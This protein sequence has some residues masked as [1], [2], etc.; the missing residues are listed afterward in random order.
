MQALQRE[1]TDRDELD[2][3][4]LF[5]DFTV[6]RASRAAAGACFRGRLAH[7]ARRRAALTL[8]AREAR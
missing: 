3:D 4:V 7:V 8:A 5:I 1:R 2:I 6:V